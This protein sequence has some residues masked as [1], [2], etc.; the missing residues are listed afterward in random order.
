[1]KL[2]VG[3][4]VGPG[5]K[6]VVHR[7]DLSVRYAIDKNTGPFTEVK[8]IV[9]DDT[10]GQWGRAAARNTVMSLEPDADWYYFLDA[11]DMMHVDALTVA[12]QELEK[13]PGLAGIWG[14]GWI[15]YQGECVSAWEDRVPLVWE[16][17]IE[18]KNRGTFGIGMFVRGPEAR[19]LRFDESVPQCEGFEFCVSFIAGYPYVKAE[20]PVSLVDRDTAS[21]SDHYSECPAPWTRAFSDHTLKWKYRGRGL[22]SQEELRARHFAENERLSQCWSMPEK[23][24]M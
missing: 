12:G 10:K 22:L 17:V 4:P 8:T 18:H 16:D 11:D 23:L 21:S 13:D 2:V 1:M 6:R 24:P 20:R 14:A 19:E 7:A 9:I 3:I 5:H 15:W